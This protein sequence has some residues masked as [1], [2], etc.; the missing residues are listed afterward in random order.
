M[1]Q[2]FSRVFL[3]GLLG[4]LLFSGSSLFGQDAPEQAFQAALEQQNAGQFAEAAEAY[5][6]VVKDYPTSA[7]VSDAQ[8]RLGYVNYLLGKYDEALANFR[9]ILGPPAPAALRQLGQALIPQAL[10]AKASALKP[11]DA[12]RKTTF[13]EAI[14]EFDTYIEKFPRGDDLE[15]VQYGRALA[16]YQL[17]RYDEAVT[18]LRSNLQ[19]FARSESILDTQYLL[20][21]TLATQGNLA[22]IDAKTLAPAAVPLFTEAEKL[23]RD[24]TRKG[25]DVA[26]GNDAQFQL[27]ELYYNWAAFA[28]K[29]Q[30]PPLFGQAMSAYRKVE[31]KADMVAAQKKRLEGILGRIRAAGQA[32]QVD[33]VRQ[34]QRL[35][36][37]EQAKLAS[38][39]G[40]ADQTVTA[41]VKVG[42]AFFQLGDYDASRLLLHY[43]QP[44]VEAAEQKK[45]LLYYVAMTYAMQQQ[46]DKAVAA[47]DAFYQ[48]YPRDP[49][50][51]NLPL[52]M[53]ALFLQKDDSATAAK[54][55]DQGTEFY[56]KSD[57][58]I[59]TLTQKA[60]ALVRL[61][62]YDEA[63]KT[64]TDVL[65]TS[66]R[67]EI[68][69]AAESGVATIDK[70]IGKLPEAIAGFQGVQ[71]KY[72]ETEFGKQA[73]FWVA[74]L[75]F[76]S[77]DAAGAVPLFQSFL[78]K[79]AQSELAS[80]ALFGM[81]Q[82]QL[83]SGDQAG[84]LETFARVAEKYPKSEAAPFSYFQR[85]TIYGS[86]A[87]ADKMLGLMREFIGKYPDDAN[88]FYAYD[89]IGQSQIN[90]GDLPAAIATYREM[91]DG[92]PNN[93]QAPQAL[94]RV[95]QLWK[96]TAT[97]LGRYLAL[98]EEQR[99]TW[100]KGVAE[101]RKAGEELIGKYPESPQVAQALE[102]LLDDQR[103][104]ASASEAA[105]ADVEK[106]FRDL[107]AK[108][109]GQP[110]TRNKVLFAL[111]GYLY[112]ADAEKALAL[113]NEAFDPALVYA[114]ADIDLYGA[115]LIER[116][117]FAKANEVYL[118]LAKD[119]P[120]PPGAD[121]R[122]APPL[123]MGAQSIALYGQGKVLQ[124]QGKTAAAAKLFDRL[125]A[126]YPWSPKILEAS[127][128]IAQGLSE[129][130]KYDEALPILGQIIRAT[131]ATAELRANA[132]LMTGRIFEAKGNVE[133][134][135]D[136]YAKIATFYQGVPV[137][138]SEGLWNAAKLILEKQLPAL[139]DENKQQGQRAKAKRYLETLIQ[140]FPNSPHAAEAKSK[141]GSLGGQ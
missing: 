50:A 54:Y 106:Y 46:V 21:L 35:Q 1:N 79:N 75:T 87:Q 43:I 16:L 45:A 29:E 63:K 73:A 52:L 88:A 89:A 122:Q 84:A 28:P 26:L 113:M 119:Y 8:F 13:E 71:E 138:A 32:G 42:Q 14:K 33:Q 25:T 4:S 85:A 72:P 129:E 90:A 99:A 68:K 7:V 121:P 127:Y 40:G 30:K 141:L 3:A 115:A 102:T 55:F 95:S 120:N 77:G 41:Q 65:K 91:V 19:Q 116:K 105:P 24:I 112:E 108:F 136:N 139:K 10:A 135:I 130:K 96:Q 48:A 66:P 64:Y 101:S 97:S 110:G 27:G 81:A 76:Q 62:K 140:N 107:A 61:Q 17:A 104:L 20:A 132:M 37:R 118:K 103:L 100:E 23:L 15:S 93:P 34:L 51:E 53:G 22:S 5:A 133:V 70:D 124:E 18:G 69:A 109:E 131:T 125:K 57:Y 44:K 39:E 36:E 128:G 111:A 58:L 117:D 94:L 12:Q 86:M 6:G 2:I 49:M 11:D 47:Y 137:A 134:A 67:E 74:Q 80:S 126:L 9:Q 92:Q 83:Q 114:P 59:D 78:D 82:A 56:P 31:P 38:I 123:V 98:N 60:Q